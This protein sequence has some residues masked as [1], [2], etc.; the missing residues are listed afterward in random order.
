MN[1]SARSSD[2]GLLT[3]TESGDA[4]A[5]GVFFARYSGQLLGYVRQR[6]GSADMAA[7]LSSETF[8]AGLL[9]VHRGHASGVEDGLTWLRG[10]A[11]HKIIDSYRDGRLQDQARTQLGLERIELQEGDRRAIERLAAFETPL[12][13]ALEKL[14]PDEREAVIARV[15]LEHEYAVIAQRSGSSEPAVRQRVTRGLRR[16]RQEIGGHDR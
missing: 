11:R 5:F 6:V 1:R 13:M 2:Q 16:L 10:I 9:S 15:V 8:A 7:D 4:E 14:S 12:H 3:A